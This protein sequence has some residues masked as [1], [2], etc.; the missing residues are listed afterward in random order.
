MKKIT[1]KFFKQIVLAVWCFCAV[2]SNA[3]EF[4]RV[5]SISLYGAP[6]Y[7]ADFKHFDYVNPAAPKRGRAVMPEYGG[8]DNFNPFIFKGNAARSVAGLTLDTLGVTPDRKSV[9]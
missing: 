4:N 9:V 3:A 8:F 2:E 5:K 7:S 1:N 6:K